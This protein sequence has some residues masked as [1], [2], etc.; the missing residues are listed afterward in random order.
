M[1]LTLILLSSWMGTEFGQTQNREVKVHSLY[2]LRHLDS[3]HSEIGQESCDQNKNG[4]PNCQVLQIHSSLTFL[5]P[6]VPMGWWC[7]TNH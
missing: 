4:C 5:L 3:P 7:K 2:F 6:I 1:T